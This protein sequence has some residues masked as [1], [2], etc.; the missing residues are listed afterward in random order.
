MTTQTQTPAT[1]TTHEI[2]ERAQAIYD[3]ELRTQVE[4]PE[5]LGKFITI[6]VLTGAYGIGDDHLKTVDTFRESHPDAVTC[7]LRIGHPA[8]VRLR[9]PRLI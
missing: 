5:N 7:T 9:S 3:R 4:T 1:L 8:T 2:G 6:D